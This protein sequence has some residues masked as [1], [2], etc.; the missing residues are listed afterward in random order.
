MTAHSAQFR[1]Y[2]ELNDFIVPEKRKKR[3]NYDF[4]GHPSVKDAIE[5]IG[6]PHTEVDLI[7]VNGSSVGF[8]YQLQDNDDIAVYP[9]FESLDILPLV[10]LRQKPLRRSRFILDVHL[11]KLAGLLRLLGF[12]A[13]YQNDYDD[14]EIVDIATREKRIVLTRDQG[15]LKHKSLTH[16]YWLRSQQ[17][18]EQLEE[19]CLRYDL[20]SQIQPFHRCIKCNGLLVPVEKE[21]IEHQLPPQVAQ[22]YSR[23][24]R[25][26]SCRQIYWQG[27]HYDELQKIVKRIKTIG[28]KTHA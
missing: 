5:A 27:S 11:G 17:T 28:E 9:V 18:L 25:C 2:E 7:M 16:G 10:K 4:N 24:R 23:Y 3:F 22:T 8:D 21:K 12:D 19:V 26:Q 13:L 1:F 6:V 14:H 15:L 20:F